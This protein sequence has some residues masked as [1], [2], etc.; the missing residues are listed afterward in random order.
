MRM[1][2]RE[3]RRE[4]ILYGC[5]RLR[6][7]RPS[8]AETPRTPQSAMIPMATFGKCMTT[9]GQFTEQAKVNVEYGQAKTRKRAS[10]DYRL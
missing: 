1:L 6:G 10:A 5:L 9:F 4:G 7:P 8:P 2:K 3:R